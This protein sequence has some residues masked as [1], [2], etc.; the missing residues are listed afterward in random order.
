MDPGRADGR[1]CED[2][3]GGPLAATKNLKHNQPYAFVPARNLETNPSMSSLWQR[4]APILVV[5]AAAAAAVVAFPSVWEPILRA[6]GWALV[7]DEPVAPADIIVVSLDS[8]DALALEAADLVQSGIAPQVAVF[9]D[10]PDE[11]DRE[12]IR[13]GL[14][15]DDKSARQIRYLRSLGVTDVMQIPGTNDELEGEIQVLPAWC[16][17]HQFRSIV[18]VVARS[19]SRRSRRLLDRAMKGQPTRVIVRPT[20]YSSFKPDRWWE[21][22][23][24]IRTEIIQLQKLVLD[25]ILHPMSF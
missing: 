16:D 5:V 7:I 12:F 13:R 17:R 1:D 20:R 10:P 14:P 21:T 11:A 15:Y 6:A 4:W 8:T 19:D 24:G 23:G 18:F 2:E 9:T 3:R 22:R 25:I